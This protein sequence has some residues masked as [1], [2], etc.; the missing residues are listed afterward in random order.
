MMVFMSS[1]ELRG[2]RERKASANTHERLTDRNF[3]VFTKDVTD[4]HVY[5]INIYFSF[6]SVKV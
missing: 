1:M 4:P 2:V 5:Y 3:C 6:F